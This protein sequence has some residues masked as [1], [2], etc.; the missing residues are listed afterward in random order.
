MRGWLTGE[1]FVWLILTDSWASRLSTLQPPLNHRVERDFI[2]RTPFQLHTPTPNLSSYT[3]SKISSNYF[4]WQQTVFLGRLI[5]SDFSVPFSSFF[6]P[7]FK[8]K[9]KR[10][11]HVENDLQLCSRFTQFHLYDRACTHMNI[12][13]HTHEHTH[14]NTQ[15]CLIRQPILFR[16]SGICVSSQYNNFGILISA[17]PC[18]QIICQDKIYFFSAMEEN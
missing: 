5:V 3:F 12:H 17:I 7:V 8:E 13:M 10:S 11:L 9:F 2:W 4:P 15:V 6:F 16:M 14:T 1:L 18:L